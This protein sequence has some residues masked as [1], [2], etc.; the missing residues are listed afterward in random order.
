MID[1]GG[2]ATDAAAVAIIY[3][4]SPELSVILFWPD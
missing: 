2:L 3:W 4:Q 1:A